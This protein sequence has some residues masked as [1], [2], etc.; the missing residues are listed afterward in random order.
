MLIQQAFVAHIYDIKNM[1][2]TIRVEKKHKFYSEAQIE[3]TY[4]V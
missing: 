1:E 2:L 4:A 3:E